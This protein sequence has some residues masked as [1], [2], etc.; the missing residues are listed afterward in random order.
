LIEIKVFISI[1]LGAVQPIENPVGG[2]HA[3]KTQAQSAA[4]LLI[5]IS[6]PESECY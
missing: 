3:G 2:D 5:Y 4:A 1:G 6:A